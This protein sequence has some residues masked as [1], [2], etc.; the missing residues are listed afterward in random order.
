MNR[1]TSALLAATGF[2]AVSIL[3][4]AGY[5]KAFV[6]PYPEIKISS[7]STFA[8]I[9]MGGVLLGARRLAAD[10]AWIELLQYYGS[11]ET[12]LDKDTEFRLS[13]DMTKYLFGV[14][15]LE[16]HES[17]GPGS[18]EDDDYYHPD[19]GGVYQGLYSHCVNV[20]KLDPFF[21]YILSHG[22]SGYIQSK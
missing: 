3:L 8:A 5:I 18:K 19:F 12:P 14:R 1:S 21:S 11:P 15:H 7:E 17:R 10:V 22:R 9:D 6:F 4:S 20:T 13:W 16:E 2:L